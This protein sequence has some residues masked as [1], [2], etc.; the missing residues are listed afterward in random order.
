MLITQSNLANS[1]SELG[2]HEEALNLRRDVYSGRLKLSGEEHRDTLLAAN[3][4]AISLT[5]LKRFEESKSVLRQMTPLARRILGESDEITLKMRWTYAQSLCQD[6]S[7]TLDDLREAVTTLEDAE[8]TA[9]RVFGGSHPTTEGL[10]G[11]LREVRAALRAREAGKN[12]V[13]VRE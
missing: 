12:V 11:A 3:N 13:F 8:R 5:F 10:E 6:A 4:Y 1:Y 9:R 7:A 2:R